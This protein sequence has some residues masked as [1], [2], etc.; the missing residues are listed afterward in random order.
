MGWWSARRE[1]KDMKKS[2]KSLRKANK[3]ILNSMRLSKSDSKALRKSSNYK[4]KFKSSEDDD[5]T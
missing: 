5:D 3:A 1:L 4:P 2:L